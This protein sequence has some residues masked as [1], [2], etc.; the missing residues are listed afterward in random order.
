[1]PKEL[2]RGQFWSL[3]KKA[4]SVIQKSGCKVENCFA[5]CFGSN[6]YYDLVLRLA[7]IMT[8]TIPVTINW[9][10]DT[11]DR[12]FYKIDLTECRLVV[13]DSC[14][15]AEHLDSINKQFPR[16]PIFHVDHLDRQEEIREDEFAFHIDPEFTRIIVFTSGTTGQPKGVQ[17]PYRAYQTNRSTFEQFLEIKPEDRFAVL[18]VNPLHHANSTAI[19][20][21]AMRR[22]GSQIHLIE[23]YSSDYWKILTHV[24]FRDYD[25]VVAPTVSRHFDFLENLDA[26]NSL[27]VE[28]ERLKAAMEKTDFLIGSAPVGPTT[29]RR[30]QHYASQIPSVRFGSTETCLQIIGIPRHLWEKSKL[31]IF[32]RGWN[33]QVKG[34]P[35]PG[36]YIGRPHPPHTRARIVKS[37]TPDDTGYMKDCDIGQPGYLITR[38]KNLM[39]GYV[40]DEEETRKVFH[41]GWYTGLKDIC[42]VLINEED[43]ELDYY[44]VSRESTLLIR[45]GVNYSYDQ[46]N[47]EL[48]DFVSNQYGLPEDS[49]D[50]SVVGLKVNSEHED[51]CCVAIEMR[52]EEARKKIEEI[53]K[54]FKDLAKQHVSKGARPDYVLFGPIPRNFKGSVLVKELTAQFK[55]RLGLKR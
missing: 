17:L 13:T 4:G 53:E 19:T 47:S 39:S 33:H 52:D 26:Q 48:M 2:T 10:A 9:Q 41:D 27:P 55:Q 51:S 20:D 36:Y 23:R 30:V 8:G 15:S 31:R 38:G 29:I 46:I 7:A 28:M 18:V 24:V 54:T 22:P 43:G 6:H 11:I 12:I 49:F 35:Y 1:M 21:W 45:G 40:K 25:R 32:Q 3:A 16:L 5:H 42:F 37:I 44:W 50:V 14:F 34:E